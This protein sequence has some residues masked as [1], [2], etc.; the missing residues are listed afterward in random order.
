MTITNR[1]SDKRVIVDLSCAVTLANGIKIP[2]IAKNLSSKGMFFESNYPLNKGVE[3]TV[4]FDVALKGERFNIEAQSQIEH[5]A[6]KM[7]M[8]EYG[9]GVHFTD[10]DEE[11]LQILDDFISKCQPLH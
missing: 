4:N 8:G 5:Q 7:S 9:I 11:S 10:I 6:T 1:R 3:V 2:G